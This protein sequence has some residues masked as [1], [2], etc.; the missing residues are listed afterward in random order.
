MCRV[1]TSQ[2][3]FNRRILFQFTEPVCFDPTSWNG[4]AGPNGS[5]AHHPSRYGAERLRDVVGSMTGIVRSIVKPG[6]T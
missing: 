2:D 1:I 4:D 6:L 5:W 3:Q